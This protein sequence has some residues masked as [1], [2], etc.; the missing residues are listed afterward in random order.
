MMVHMYVCVCL[1][2]YVDDSLADRVWVDM[3]ACQRLVQNICTVFH[4]KK[5]GNKSGGNN[6]S[7]E[8]S[9]GNVQPSDV[10][11]LNTDAVKVEPR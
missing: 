11:V 8:N 10:H 2:V 4:T 3:D 7:S 9:E 5:G 6:E 1:Q